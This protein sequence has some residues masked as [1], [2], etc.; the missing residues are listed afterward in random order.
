MEAKQ[1]HRKSGR[2]GPRID[3]FENDEDVLQR[4]QSKQLFTLSSRFTERG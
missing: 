2:Q 1:Q 3:D 4:S